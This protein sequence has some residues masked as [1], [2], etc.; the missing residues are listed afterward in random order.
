[1]ATP[2]AYGKSQDNGVFLQWNCK[3]DTAKELVKALKSGEQD[4]LHSS[5]DHLGDRP[6]LPET[7]T[8]VL[9][10]LSES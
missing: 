1:M 10:C 4:L 3:Y 8:S 7:Q 6:G 9:P 5:G 2:M